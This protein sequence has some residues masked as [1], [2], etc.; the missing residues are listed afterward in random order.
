MADKKL[1]KR[2][3]FIKEIFLPTNKSPRKEYLTEDEVN[4][5]IRKISS[6]GSRYGFVGDNESK[7]KDKS[8]KRKHK[9]DVWI[10]KEI[11]KDMNLLNRFNEIRFILDWATDTKANIFD[12]TFNQALE[13]QQ[14]W[15][16]EMY[17]KL[18]IEKLE[19]PE[20]DQRRIIFRC[21][22][23]KHFF[24][25][26][27]SGDLKY[28]GTKMK[29]CVKSQTYA[30]KV[31]NLKSLMLSLRDEKNDPHI[32]IEIDTKSKRIIQQYG[33]ANTPIKP[34]LKMMMVEFALFATEFK[35]LENEEVLKFLNLNYI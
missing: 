3:Q 2:E 19:M 10:A 24:Y 18:D 15:H 12:H 1:T 31:K 14:A 34:E 32:T 33:R 20:I 30:N 9:Y 11:K 29:N 16:D 28:E 22:D 8:D 27:N 21:G 25:L 17:S 7:N 35:G 4:K 6:L 26:L 5:V 13:L 23:K